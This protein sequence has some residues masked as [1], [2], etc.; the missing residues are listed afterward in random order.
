MTTIIKVP[1][2][3]AESIPKM[4]LIPAEIQKDGPANVKSYFDSSVRYIDNNNFSGSLRGR[5]IHGVEFKVPSGYT[6]LIM[7]E[8]R[9]AYTEEDEKELTA[10]RSFKSFKYWNLDREP[11]IG[12]RIYQATKW[13]DI[14]SA[15][16]SSVDIELKREDSVGSLKSEVSM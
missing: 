12:D 15:L 2:N 9:K 5:P 4:H 14:A 7:N 10:T 8:T 16:H 11:T 6:G 1:E 13:I 3:C